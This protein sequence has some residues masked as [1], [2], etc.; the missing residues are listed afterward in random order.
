M[1]GEVVAKASDVNGDTLLQ[2]S[3]NLQDVEF[4]DRIILVRLLMC[5]LLTEEIELKLF[6]MALNQD[7]WPDGKSILDCLKEVNY[8]REVKDESRIKA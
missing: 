4:M 3:T 6:K 1:Y 5:S 7:V 8:L 2:I